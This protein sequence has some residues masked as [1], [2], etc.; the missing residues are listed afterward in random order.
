M[1]NK[2]SEIRDMVRPAALTTAA[3][4]ART[5]MKSRRK[6]TMRALRRKTDLARDFSNSSK[7]VS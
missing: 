4:H 7:T 6:L 1:N 3:T 5:K 2:E